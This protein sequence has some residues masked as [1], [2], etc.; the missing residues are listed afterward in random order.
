[1]ETLDQH[2]ANSDFATL[3]TSI[4]LTNHNAT[5]KQSRGVIHPACNNDITFDLQ[6]APN[7]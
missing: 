7:S 1:M 3:L 2:I 5:I 4:E 6:V